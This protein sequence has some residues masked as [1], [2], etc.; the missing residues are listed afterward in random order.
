M[1][2]RR[3]H[4]RATDFASCGQ[5][6]DKALWK[7]NLGVKLVVTTRSNIH[8]DIRLLLEKLYVKVRFSL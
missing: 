7:D 6:G 5:I 4:R 3:A 1:Q 2:S 8:T